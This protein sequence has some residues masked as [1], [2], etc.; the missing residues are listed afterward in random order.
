[1]FVMD[2]FVLH[3]VLVFVLV[4]RAVQMRVFVGMFVLVLVVLVFVLVDGPVRVAVFAV[5]AHATDFRP[6]EVLP[7]ADKR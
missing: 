7:Y 4:T 1:M 2:V 6:T 5:L 3:I